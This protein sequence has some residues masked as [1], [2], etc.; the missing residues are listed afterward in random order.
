CLV[1]FGGLGWGL[2]CVLGGFGGL[3][4]CVCG[5]CC[6][7]WFGLF[8]CGVVFWFGGCG[9]CCCVLCCVWCWWR[10]CACLCFGLC[11]FVFWCCSGVG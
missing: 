1:V 11:W 4:V 10:G 2:V 5:G 6:C 3:C 7:L 9:G 8:W